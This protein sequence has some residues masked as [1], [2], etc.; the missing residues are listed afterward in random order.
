MR[1]RRCAGPDGSAG[2]SSGGSSAS[3]CSPAWSP[4]SSARCVAVPLALVGTI[5][6]LLFPGTAG[7]AAA[8]ALL[9]PLPDRRRL[10]DHAVHLG[11]DRA[12]VRRPADPQGGARRRADRRVA[13]G[14]DGRP[15][16]PMLPSLVTTSAPSAPT[17]TRPAPGWSGSCPGRS[18]S[19]A[20]SSGSCPGSVTSGTADPG[21]RRCLGVVR[22]CGGPAAGGWSSRCSRWSPDGCD[23]SPRPD[24]PTAA[25]SLPGDLPGGP[26]RR[27]GG[28]PVRGSLRGGARRGLP[29]PGV[30]LA[31]T[32]A[33][34]GPSRLDGPRARCRPLPCLPPPRGCPDPGGGA[35]RRRVLRRAGCRPHGRAHGARPRR[36][37]A[38]GPTCRTGPSADQA[39]AA[40]PR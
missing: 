12:A 32:R 13:A 9:L 38:H 29:R 36:G 20:C 2:G 37:A 11:G 22:G 31:A 19:A 26:S 14:S 27:G 28:R 17:R 39:A 6:P 21:R 4:A 40:V 30:P 1:R 8:G 15:A 10:A 16:E 25:C 18:T 3:C 35:L 5:G 34:R 7:R 24:G 33:G 23:G